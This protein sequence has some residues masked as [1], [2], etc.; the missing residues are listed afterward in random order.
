MRLAWREKSVGLSNG[1]LRDGCLATL[2]SLVVL[3][4]HFTQKQTCKSTV[5]SR[6]L[7]QASESLEEITIYTSL[8]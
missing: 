7:E 4:D 5:G 8:S 6:F 2:T 1:F 3:R